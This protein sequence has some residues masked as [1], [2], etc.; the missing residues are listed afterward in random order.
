MSATAPTADRMGGPMTTKA[1]YTTEEWVAIA[2]APILAGAYIAASD[3]SMFGLLPEMKGLYRAITELPA[4]D[5]A[6]DL[7]AAVVGE[8]SASGDDKMAMPDVKNN[9][10]AAAQL[11]D[12]LEIDLEALDG[13]ATPA[14]AA[15]YKRWLTDIA[16]ATAEAGREGG[17]LGIGSV[18]VSDKEQ[19]ALA[20]LRREL[21]VR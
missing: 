6:A 17:F 7:V 21:G 12:Q 16:Q 9:R 13:K 5:E 2:R 11:L 15:A 1:D 4:P 14:E 18:T 10:T 3:M 8:I 19:R 20:T